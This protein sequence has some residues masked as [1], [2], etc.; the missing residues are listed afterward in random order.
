VI[1]A[2]PTC[3]AD[4]EFRYDDSLVRVCAH[5]RAAV[6]RGDRGPETLGRFA[7]LTPTESPLRLFA[8][9]TVRGERF[10]LVGM[11]QL[12]HAAGGT[13]QEW[14][15][16]LDGGA[17]A[18]IAEAQGRF[19]VTREVPDAAAPPLASLAPGAKTELA[20]KPF[21]VDER[22]EATYV[23]AAG[24]I[25]FKLAPN[26]TYRFA[27]LSDFDGHFA[28]V[29][30]SDEPPT[31][32]VGD[33]AT[34][35]ELHVTGGEAPAP[36]TARAAASRLAC[37]NCN[38]SLELRA[39]DESLRVACP[40]CGTLVDVEQGTAKIIAKQRE[41]PV[42]RIPL[43]S[44]GTLPEGAFTVIGYFER[45]A[46]VDGE[47]FPFYEYLLHDA[48]IGFRWLVQSDG[49]WS[50][51]Q[52]VPAGAVENLGA[53]V[54]YGGVK[55]K[56]FASATLRV[57]AVLGECY[58]RVAVGDEVVGEDYIAPPAML[59]REETADE[60]TWSL[61]TY[62]TPADVTRAFPDATNLGRPSGVAP[63]QP[64]P[65]GY[66]GVLLA[67]IGI[68]LALGVAQAA[69]APS[70]KLANATF[71]IPGI[72]EPPPAGT[73]PIVESDENGA[74]VP[75]AAPPAPAPGESAPVVQFSDKFHIDGGQNLAIDVSAP[76]VNNWAYAAIDLVNDATGDVTSFD[77]TIEY[78][79]GFEDGESWTE[80][81]TS[82]RQVLS[83]LPAGDYVL[84]VEAQQGSPRSLLFGATVVQGVFR[85]WPLTVALSAFAAGLFILAIHAGRFRKRKWDNANV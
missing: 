55:F 57:E 19:Y 73:V 35:A 30:Y 41:V 59:S 47:R 49:H 29:D 50:F 37:P 43:G 31:V 62:L 34:L 68:A 60:L 54:K 14:Y 66:V 21:T 7:D 4:V 81:S 1:V 38:G 6:V 71:T 15:A 45:S 52:P 8:A 85:P 24:E 65:S 2:C 80:G 25:P 69:S 26:T 28:T 82:D 78:Y 44:K 40:Y 75:N 13:W 67:A 51:V 48:A 23:A 76:L 5:C 17:W 58:W 10:L 18:W 63:N 36:S 74:P 33:Q 70:T 20:G 61:G 72:G 56:K 11:A 9:G 46:L 79:A 12:K 27:D 39:P 3:G 53:R 22:G 16:K 83:P 77:E 32:Y 64:Y 42:P 84:R